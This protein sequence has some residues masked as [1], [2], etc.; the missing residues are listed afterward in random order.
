MTL[1]EHEQRVMEI[2]APFNR[3]IVQQTVRG[4]Q[5]EI[6]N[7]TLHEKVKRLEVLVDQVQDEARHNVPPMESPSDERTND[8]DVVERVIHRFL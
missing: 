8:G 3:S 4:G 7:A 6:E 2:V 1:T 5:F